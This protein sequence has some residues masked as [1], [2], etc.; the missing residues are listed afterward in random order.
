[1]LASPCIA[2]L[3]GASMPAE[4]L[5]DLV[6]AVQRRKRCTLKA[7]A[8]AAQV[9]RTTL[10]RWLTGE[11]EPAE[12]QRGVLAAALGVSAKRLGR[13][14]SIAQRSEGIPA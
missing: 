1:M 14:L 4:T 11:C 13:V 2:V 7:I 12:W 8:A 6:T 10:R 3:H 9:H 5:Q